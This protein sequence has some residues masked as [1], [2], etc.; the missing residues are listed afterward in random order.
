MAVS[1]A[2][3][4]LAADL[5]WGGG[6]T[7]VANG[8]PVAGGSGNWKLTAPLNWATDAA[9][10]TYQAW[11]NGAIA[12][13]GGA[14]GSGLS[15]GQYEQVFVG[16]IV[17]TTPV[18]LSGNAYLG[19]TSGAVVDTGAN[20]V[21]FN[22]AWLRGSTGFTKLGS[23]SLEIFTGITDWGRFTGTITHGAGSIGLRSRDSA[24]TAG[25]IN[26]T[27]GAVL[28]LVNSGDTAYGSGT[29]LAIQVSDSA[30]A[31]EI[32]NYKTGGGTGAVNTLGTLTLGSRTV[33]FTQAGGYTTSSFVFGKTTLTGAATLNV[34]AGMGVTL[35]AVGET[36]GTR[37]LATTGA[38]TLTLTGTS[39][40]TGNT[41]V[42]SALTL[43]DNAVLA[44]SI[45]AS[46]VSNR[47]NGAG[48]LQ[49]DGDFDF[50][51]G[52]AGT[53]PGASWTIVDVGTLNETFG[54]TFAV[55]GFT[56]NLNN[57][58]SKVSGDITYTF[59]EATGSLTV[60][61]PFGS[62]IGG[63]FPGST[64]AAET[65]TQA[66]PDQDGLANAVEYVLNLNPNSGTQSG[67]PDAQKIGGNMVFTYSRLKAAVVAGFIPTVEY[68]TS[69]AAG[70]WATA[71]AGMLDV[72]DNGT[73]E[74][75]TVTIPIP[76]AVTKLFARLNVTSP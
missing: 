13:V 67:L 59:D 26:L 25:T 37:T 41:T 21:I 36:G 60:P 14:P 33:N 58:W 9:G 35:T 54:P 52:S 61:S 76:G 6:T 7:D 57:T 55:V 51:L 2:P 49:L 15:L 23:G 50:N 34:A 18:T 38:G 5:Y 30:T 64:N 22:G 74:S 24:G 32:D 72:Q 11:S 31:V 62:W 44:F 46:G 68:S 47:I 28:N 66:D 39:T 75:V 71:T 27:G 40:Y 53:T 12:H 56:D 73:T 43:A 70:N 48:T 29:P 42:G 63:Y 1:L 16:G 65:G 4:A 69:L 10:T 45:G 8:T 3:H 17:F 20:Y 19:F